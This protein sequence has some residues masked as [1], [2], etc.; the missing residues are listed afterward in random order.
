MK[1]AIEQYRHPLKG[2]SRFDPNQPGFVPEARAL[3]VEMRT[4]ICFRK[5]AVG[6][7]SI[8]VLDGNAGA[9]WKRDEGTPKLVSYNTGEALPEDLRG[10][11]LAYYCSE[12]Q[13][14]HPTAV[15]HYVLSFG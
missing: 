2:V 10:K 4:E 13:Q 3:E 1:V 12:F 15:A 7:Y 11:S 6:R 9:W 8:E 5:F 14:L